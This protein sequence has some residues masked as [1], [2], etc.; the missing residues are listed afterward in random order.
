M[1]VCSL[2]VTLQIRRRHLRS[3]Q[4]RRMEIK[5]LKVE[6]MT[7][8][9]RQWR[10]RKDGQPCQVLVQLPLLLQIVEAPTD[11]AT[12]QWRFRKVGQLCQVLVR[13]PLPL[14]PQLPLVEAPTDGEILR[15]PY[16]M[17]GLL[18]YR[19]LFLPPHL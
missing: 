14:Q 6:A 2:L 17:A 15:W 13:L 18:R 11:G 3:R 9:H 5:P 1:P 7:G 8:V 10:S 19:H 4:R 12:R 16:Q